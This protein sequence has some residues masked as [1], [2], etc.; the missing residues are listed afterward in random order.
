MN[1]THLTIF[2]LKNIIFIKIYYLGNDDPIYEA[3]KE[4]QI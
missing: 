3:A 1:A 4:T 2:I